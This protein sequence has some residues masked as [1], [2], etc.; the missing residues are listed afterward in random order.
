LLNE[1]QLAERIR[2]HVDTVI[3]GERSL[4]DRPEFKAVE[5]HR[6]AR[7]A[8]ACLEL[9][10]ARE[11][12]EVTGFEKEILHEIDGQTIR[13]VI[14]RIDRLP[15]G[16]EVII[17]YKT[18]KVDPKKWFGDRPDDPQLPLYSISAETVPA[19]VAFAVIRDEECLYRGVVTREGIFPGL[20]QKRGLHAETIIEAG[21]NMPVTIA[22]WRQTLHRLMAEF[23]SGAAS[24]DPKDGRRTCENSYCELQPLCRISELEQSAGIDST[25]AAA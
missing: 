3:N 6:L 16:K 12:F 22:E 7:L 9:E 13:L 25:E 17:D 2:T 21:R 5:G 20:P 19:A 23:L 18:G 8:A 11:P 24:I 10:K 14:D 15:D 4:N 1:E